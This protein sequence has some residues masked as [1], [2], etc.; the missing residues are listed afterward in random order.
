MSKETGQMNIKINQVY[1]HIQ[2]YI[3]IGI[4]RFIRIQEYKDTRI[5]C[6]YNDRDTVMN[7]DTKIKKLLQ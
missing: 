7:R 3:Y 1:A 2:E 4:Q 5:Q 6:R